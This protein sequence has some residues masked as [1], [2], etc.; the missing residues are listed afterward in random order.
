M[1]EN[2]R[3]IDL[4]VM[5]LGGTLVKT[6]EAGESGGKDMQLNSGLRRDSIEY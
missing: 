1:R 3:K 2:R 6:D 4:I 5:D